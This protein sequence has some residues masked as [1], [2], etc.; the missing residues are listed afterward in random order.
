MRGVVRYLLERGQYW[1]L[2][3][4]K[5]YTACERARWKDKWEIMWLIEG[6]TRGLRDRRETRRASSRR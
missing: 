2:K 1:R 5:G 4:H 3:N 6:L